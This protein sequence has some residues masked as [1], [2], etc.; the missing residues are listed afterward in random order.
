ML[1]ATFAVEA[2]AFGSRI[3][4]GGAMIPNLWKTDT[5]PTP[6]SSKS[7]SNSWMLY[8]FMPTVQHDEVHESEEGEQAR[9][10]FCQT[11]YG[12]EEGVEGKRRKMEKTASCRGIKSSGT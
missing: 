10:I 12:G 11:W 6:K 3:I 2:V 8:T 7:L 5:I 1:F 4:M 9:N